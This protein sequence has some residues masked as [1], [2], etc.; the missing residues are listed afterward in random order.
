LGDG[1]LV[2]LLKIAAILTLAPILWCYL[3]IPQNCCFEDTFTS[4][5]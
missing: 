3:S 4:T 5:Y 2:W 1:S